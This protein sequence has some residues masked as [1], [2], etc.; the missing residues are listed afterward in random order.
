MAATASAAS[1]PTIKSRWLF[2]GRVDDGTV[3]AL[4]E[5]L[6]LPAAVAA[7]LV[8]RGYAD[9]D[10][11]R[12]FLNPGLEDLHDPFLLKDMDLAVA[13]I[14]QAVALGEA[15][16]IHGDYDVDG[17]TSTVVLKKALEIAGAKPHL[18][19]STSPERRLRNAAGGG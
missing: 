18:A 4:G 1:T 14:R 2:P 7:I 8:R 5:E 15:I 11:A 12:R 17:V 10:A 3:A 9:S 13:R 6:R 16:E 19:Y